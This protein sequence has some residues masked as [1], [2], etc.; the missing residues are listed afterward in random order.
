MTK[1]TKFPYEI[2]KCVGKTIAAVTLIERDMVEE[3]LPQRQRDDLSEGCL[4]IEFDDGSQLLLGDQTDC[5]E[6]RYL[7]TDDDLTSFVGA[8]FQDVTALDIRKWSEDGTYESR[9][10]ELGHS[11]VA[12][13]RCENQ[14]RIS[15]SAGDLTLKAYV[16]GEGSYTQLQ[17]HIV[18]L[19]ASQV[20][21]NQ[22]RADRP[23][24]TG[25]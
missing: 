16:E 17:P 9:A 14:I 2:R 25:G 10:E 18:S 23:R 22:P 19:D 24:S 5:C 12:D 20:Q 6:L 3:A 11:G 21:R 4:Q 1:E 8:T 13:C 7:A 15:T